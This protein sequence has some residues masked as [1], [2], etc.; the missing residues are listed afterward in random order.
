MLLCAELTN[1]QS[2]PHIRKVAGI[3][4]KNALSSKVLLFVDII[5]RIL[6]ALKNT[7]SDGFLPMIK[8]KII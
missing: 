7:L 1:E 6:C 5:I 3:T 4:L 2:P 8:Q